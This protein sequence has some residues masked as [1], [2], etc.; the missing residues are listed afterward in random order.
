MLMAEDNSDAIATHITQWLDDR[1]RAIDEVPQQLN[2]S[3]GST[4]GYR[5]GR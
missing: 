2:R 5:A 4:A 1:L 3:N